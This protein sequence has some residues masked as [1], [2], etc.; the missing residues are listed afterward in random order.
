MTNS[1][2]VSKAEQTDYG[3]TVNRRIADWRKR[4]TESMCKTLNENVIHPDA[5]GV[6]RNDPDYENH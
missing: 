3:D 5:E 4:I 6:F 2:P 1:N